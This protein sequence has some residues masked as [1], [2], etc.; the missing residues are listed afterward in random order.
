MKV[1]VGVQA[2]K[3]KA[4]RKSASYPLGFGRAIAELMGCRGLRHSGPV[5]LFAYC[6]DQ[7]AHLGQGV[8]G[9]RWGSLDDFLKGRANTWW[10]KL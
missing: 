5:D 9:D 6:R 4:L 8:Q 3:R 10:R 1:K 2:G 7:R